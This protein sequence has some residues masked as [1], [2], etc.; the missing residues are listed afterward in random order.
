LGGGTILLQNPPPVSYHL[1]PDD[2]I[3][4]SGFQA[5]KSINLCF[6]EKT[7][8]VEVVKKLEAI[9]DRMITVLTPAS[10]VAGVIDRGDIVRAIADKHQ[11][12]IQESEIKRAREGVY[13]S[14]LPLNVIAAALEK[15]EPPKIGEPSLIS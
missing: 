2:R 12:P 10:A 3:N 15:S 11:L 7:P 4:I 14:Y 13:P 8:L 1:S 9:P 5:I 6:E